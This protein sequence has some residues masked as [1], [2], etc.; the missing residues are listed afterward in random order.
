VLRR[1]PQ[2]PRSL[3]GETPLRSLLLLIAAAARR[4]SLAP[5]RACLCEDQ[6]GARAGLRFPY[7]FRNGS[8][9]GI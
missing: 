4:A 3:R 5:G 1:T 9:A 8:L 6:R 2:T 7:P